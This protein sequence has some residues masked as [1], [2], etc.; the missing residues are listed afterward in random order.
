LLTAATGIWA[1]LQ[2]G[3]WPL[4]HLKGRAIVRLP[5]LGEYDLG[6]AV[7]KAL[8]ERLDEYDVGW[9]GDHVM[10][11]VL[12]E[13]RPARV[14]RAPLEQLIK[15]LSRRIEPRGEA[16][17]PRGHILAFHQRLL[18]ALPARVIVGSQLQF[19][20][21]RVSIEENLMCFGLLAALAALAMGSGLMG[22]PAGVIGIC[23]IVFAYGAMLF[24]PAQPYP[25]ERPRLVSGPAL[26]DLEPEP[27][28]ADFSTPAAA[29]R[30]YV[31]A[32][33]RAD[34]E[35]VQQAVSAEEFERMVK[36]VW[37]VTPGTRTVVSGFEGGRVLEVSPLSAGNAMAGSGIS[38]RMVSR[39]GTRLYTFKG[40]FTES[41]DGTWKLATKP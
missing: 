29:A 11:T 9:A 33:S 41:A 16:E 1:A 5:A 35:L 22:V 34:V 23:T 19:I 2:D 27:I 15:N 4:D 30:T 26:G 13:A 7:T 24:V 36:D 32:M 40:V 6:P 14:G 3:R 12:H 21:D 8:G 20:H 38:V 31:E 25:D 28:V 10:I 18:D 37:Q 39:D 17:T